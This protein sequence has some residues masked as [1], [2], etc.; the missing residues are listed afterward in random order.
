MASE[1]EVKLELSAT[2]MD[3]LLASDLLGEPETVLTQ[4]ATYFDT[5]DRRLFREGFTL[6]IRQSGDLRTQTVKAT[7]PGASLFARSEWETPVEGDV[8]VLDHTNPVR[9]EFGGSIALSPAF[10]VEVERRVWNIE[11]SGSTIEVALDVGAAVS[12]DR[13][14]PIREI[15]LELKDGD[16]KHLFDLARRVGEI[17]PVRFGV[18]SKAERGF[19]L[20]DQQKAFHKAEPLHLDKTMRASPLFQ[21]I[22]ASC[23][24]Q[25]RLNE[26]VLM[27]QRNVE[28]LHQARVAVRRLRS[29]FTLFK[30]L[31]AGDEPLRLKDEFRWLA[32]TLGDAR[33]LDVLLAKAKDADLRRRL[34]EA[35][36]AAY[37]Q[38]TE[39]LGSERAYALMLDFNEWLH[40]GD[41]LVAP[42]SE[43]Q[44]DA[45]APD[46]ACVVMDHM[47][48]KLKKDGASLAE[49]DDEHRHDVRKDAKKLRYAAEFFGSLFDNKKGMRRQ[50]RFLAAMEILQDQLGA[51]NDLATGPSVLEK[52]GL[53]DHP[54]RDSLVPASDK[55]KLISATQVAVDDV[56]ETKRFWR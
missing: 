7:G 16:R 38:A 24:R 50:K 4:V 37:D 9:S 28:A 33:N 51:L 26:D 21:E 20:V 14:A 11:Q 34:G 54:A 36:A 56:L 49:T 30:P 44:R 32:G 43:E 29:A 8:P 19:A 31:L 1:I 5:D 2:G 13:Y 39:A 35:R 10:R 22:A 12:G 40:C 45:P 27:H 42:E 6:R 53:S 41:Y 25:F 17:A 23:F 48:K 52:F 47:R 46:F 55:Q 3:A 18:R 15:E